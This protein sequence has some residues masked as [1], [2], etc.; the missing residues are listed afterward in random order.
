METNTTSLDTEKLT[1]QVKEMY[2][3]V[4][5]H[6]AEKYHFEMGRDLAVS[7]GYPVEMLDQIPEQAIESFAGVGYFFDL[8]KIKPGSHVVDLGSGSGMDAFQA[9]HYTE[10]HGSVTG[11]DITEAQLRKAERLAIE[12]NYS[13]V[14]FVNER[15]EKLS[16]EDA[17]FDYVISNGV[18][19]LSPE[20]EKVFQESARILKTGGI[21]AIADIVTVRSLPENITCNSDLWAACIGGAMQKDE[22]FK[23]IEKAGFEIDSVVENTAYGFISKSAKGA[24][25]QYGVMSISI[26][27]RKNK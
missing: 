25:K 5:L 20:K 24:T 11:V 4:A 2:T 17:S 15:I 23:L 19:N 16:F 26:L 1:Q 7:L 14:K 18:I 6:P 22:Y 9:A 8:A 12:N 21:M 10:A 13:Q 27:A 3:A